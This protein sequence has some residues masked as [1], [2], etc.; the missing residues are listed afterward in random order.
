M[1][2]EA[3][4]S[5]LTPHPR[6]RAHARP[7]I[8]FPISGIA[9]RPF[10]FLTIALL[11]CSM[12]M[13]EILLTRICS[14]RLFYHYGFLVVSNC[15][16]MIGASGSLLYVYQNAFKANPRLWVWR[17]SL[18]Y[19]VSLVLTYGF[20]LKFPT[21]P[22]VNFLSVG[23]TAW[24][25][26]FNLT[27][28]VPFFFAGSV[29]GLILTHSAEQVNRVYFFDLAAAGIGCFLSPILLWKTGAGGCLV[30]VA[31]VGVWGAVAA[32]PGSGK[33]RALTGCALLGVLG[34]FLV[35]RLDGWFPVPSKPELL[36]TPTVG[37][38]QPSK[39]PYSRWSAI[40]R[41]DL[42]DV[43]VNKRF[44]FGRGTKTISDP[45]PEMKYIVQ[46][47]TAGTTIVNWS[48]DPAHRNAL[49]KSL[50]VLPTLLK[51]EPRVLIIGVGGGN[52]VWG[53]M[54]Q[55]ARQIRG[56]E[57]N[58][59]ILDIHHGVLSR[60]SRQIIDNPRIDLVCA[61]GRSELMRD[62]AH[63]DVIQMSGVDTWT[64]LTSGAVTV[65]AHRRQ[66]KKL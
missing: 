26:L 66:E 21:P 17:F 6:V 33:W 63:Y 1:S 38:E 57:L 20:L 5:P 24:F 53:A 40:S 47:G 10:A 45:L 51:N 28:A 42:L 61:E 22:G 56:I 27:A 11:S 32:L 31:L 12:L 14:L 41:V 34:A 7:G 3:T 48:E 13:Y 18:G 55:G 16:L 60:Y 36:V 19:V 35:P 2:R 9:G 37:Y 65:Q 52:D 62:K 46:D 59:Q 4:P 44:I 15:L 50:Y 43:P 29:I 25:T 23:D 64:S 39:L 54:T 58:Q 49:R 30:A 8:E